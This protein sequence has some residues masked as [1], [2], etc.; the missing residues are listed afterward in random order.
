MHG[1]TD[2]ITPL[3]FFDMNTLFVSA[4]I[5]EHNVIQLVVYYMTD[6]SPTY[7]YYYK[8]I[9]QA[10]ERIPSALYVKCLISVL[11]ESHEI[12]DF[13]PLHPRKNVARGH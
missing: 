10:N 1:R 12:P 5:I 3:Y 2:S 9:S 7:Y 8:K 11:I 4:H 13:L 6:V